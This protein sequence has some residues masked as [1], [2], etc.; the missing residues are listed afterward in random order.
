MTIT[1]AYEESPSTDDLKLL[2]DGI[3]AEAYLKRGLSK[4][5]SF[6]F[7]CKDNNENILGGVYGWVIYGCLHIDELWIESNYRNQGLGSKLILKALEYGK[8]NN[9]TFSTVNTMDFEARPFYEKHGYEVEFKRQGYD[10]NTS[11]YF[12]RKKLI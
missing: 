1:I 8:A 11:F 5:K 3:S 2:F 12:L 10:K 6:C 7:F 4:G 9:C